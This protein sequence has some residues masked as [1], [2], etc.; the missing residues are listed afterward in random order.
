L[1]NLKNLVLGPIKHGG[2]VIAVL[3]V[4]NKEGTISKVEEDIIEA[5]LETLGVVFHTNQETSYGVK[6]YINYKNNLKQIMNKIYE[7]SLLNDKSNTKLISSEIKNA[8]DKF[9]D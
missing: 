5:V 7:H 1:N 2:E 4:C 6:L 8:V 9:T 3:Q